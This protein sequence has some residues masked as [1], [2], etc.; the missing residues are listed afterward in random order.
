MGAALPSVCYYCSAVLRCQ[1]C[2]RGGATSFFCLG[3]VSQSV[4]IMP[5]VVMPSGSVYTAVG[6]LVVHKE[7]LLAMVRFVRLAVARF[8]RAWVERLLQVPLH[9]CPVSLAQHL[10]GYGTL[11]RA[12]LWYG[13]LCCEHWDCQADKGSPCMHVPCFLTQQVSAVK[14]V[15]HTV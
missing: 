13:T 9:A 3:A 6:S 8:Q 12:W 14:E 1:G 11:L 2:A 4:C 15:C 10:S 5:C 7:I